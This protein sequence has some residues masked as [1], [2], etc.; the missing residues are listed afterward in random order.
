MKSKLA[1]WW[2]IVAQTFQRW[3][4]HDSMAQSAALSYYTA[5]SLAPVLLVVVTIAGAVFGKDAVRGRLVHQFE[6]LMGRDQAVLVQTV[7][8]GAGKDDSGPIAAIAGVVMLIVGATAVFAQLQSALNTIWEVKPKKGHFVSDFLRKR[9]LSFALV[10]GIGFL[11]LVSLVLS[12]GLEAVQSHF[13]TRFGTEAAWLGW[14]NAAISFALFALL[15]AMIFRILP[16][17]RIPWRDVRVGA[18]GT[19]L[20]FVIGKW[21]IG[22]YLGRAAVGSAYGAAGSVIVL[23]LWVYYVSMIVLLGAEF[24]RA[25]SRRFEKHAVPPEKGAKKGKPGADVPT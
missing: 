17:A 1:V 16:D 25:Y 13:E 22:L 7:L 2:R 6:G 10:L 3:F 21:A 20:L 19:A 8:K 18:L 14:L 24:T 4:T 23:L 9:M 5:F 15:F 11:L 12:A